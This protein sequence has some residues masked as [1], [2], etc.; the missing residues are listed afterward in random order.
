MTITIPRSPVLLV[1]VVTGL[2][3]GAAEWVSGGG[4]GPTLIMTAIPIAYAAVVYALAR[5]HPTAGVLAGK[6]Q[7]ERWVAID[8]EASA[9]TLG[10]TAVVV[11]GAFV[12]TYASGGPWQPFAFVGSV[13]AVSYV[14]S[15]VYLQSRR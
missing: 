7:D 9:W 3:I 8:L 10:L 5:H 13:I 11:L 6:P 15:L 2:A 14:G 1:G 4:P 12:W